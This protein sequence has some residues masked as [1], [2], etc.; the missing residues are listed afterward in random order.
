MTTGKFLAIGAAVM[1]L[2]GP[3]PARAQWLNPTLDAQRW[4]NLRKH[5]QHQCSGARQPVHHP[6][7]NRL[8]TE[9]RKCM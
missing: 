7:Q 1:L 5:Q 8:P 6:D 4:D 2:T 3:A 9:T